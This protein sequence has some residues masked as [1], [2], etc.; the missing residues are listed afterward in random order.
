MVV[1][2][3]IPDG[4]RTTIEEEEDRVKKNFFGVI[5]LLTRITLDKEY[6]TKNIGI[7]SNI[8]VLKMFDSGV[9]LSF[10][11]RTKIEEEREF[12]VKKRKKRWTRERRSSFSVLR[13]NGPGWVKDYWNLFQYFFHA[14]DF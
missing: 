11:R 8:F 2:R 9:F 6:W 12:L 14:D 5:L 1:A 4:K 3:I 7:S 13:S 10:S